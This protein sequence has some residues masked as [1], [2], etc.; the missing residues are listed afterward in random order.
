MEL[1]LNM[2]LA[3]ND[4]TGVAADLPSIEECIVDY[5]HCSDCT[6]LEPSIMI[7]LV[8]ELKIA[9]TISPDSTSA[10]ADRLADRHMVYEN[11][12]GK[13]NTTYGPKD[14]PLERYKIE[15]DFAIHMTRIKMGKAGHYVAW[16]W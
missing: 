2:R 8:P 1:I 3:M 13:Y 15:D 12:D 5:G 9:I 6:M 16:R 11:I 4:L 7:K 10:I 14:K